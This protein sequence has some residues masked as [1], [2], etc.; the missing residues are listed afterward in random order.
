MSKILVVYYTFEGST[1]SIAECIA[2]HLNADLLEIKPVKELK[3]KGFSKYIWGGYQVVMGKKPEIM[4]LNKN[5]KDYDIVLVGTPIW[6][7]T[8][9]PPIKTL[10]EENYIKGKKIAYFYGHEG[11]HRRA[12]DKAKVVIEKNNTFI[13]AK[14]FLNPKKNLD[15]CSKDAKSWA[16]QLITNNI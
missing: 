5:L 7:G 2:K 16:E 13:G 14:D 6:A 12:I 15:K 10:L 4:P 11:G 1:K 9:A 3:S 8:Y